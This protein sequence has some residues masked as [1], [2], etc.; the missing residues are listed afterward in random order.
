MMKTISALLALIAFAP[1]IAQKKGLALLTL[2]ALRNHPTLAAAQADVD[3]ANARGAQMSA[4]FNPMLS[5][6]GYAAAGKGESIF[7]SSVDPINYSLM[8]DKESA[9]AN[10]MFMWKVFSDGRAS[11]ARRSAIA[12]AQGKQYDLAAARLDVLR[13][14]RM[15]FSMSMHAGQNVEAEQGG[16]AAAQELLDVTQSLYDAG[17]IPEAFLFRAKADL[18]KSS[19]RLA[20]A[21]SAED[22]AMARLKEAAALPQMEMFEMGEW[23]VPLSAPPTLEEALEMGMH[24]RPE[25]ASL[26][27]TAKMYRLQARAARQSMGPEMSV[28]GMADALAA[29]NGSDSF[30]KAGLVLSLPLSDGGMRRAEAAEADAQAKAAEA[31]KEAA[32]QRIEREIAEAW[33]EWV[34]APHVMAAAEAEVQAAEEGYRVSKIRYE[35][36]KSIQAEVS[37]ALADLVAALGS[38]AQAQEF[39]HLAWTKL[40]R[41]LGK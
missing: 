12:I 21:K 7:T 9:D 19:R 6:N 38:R 16:V 11:T 13:D 27:E 10:A 36:G 23:D 1:L 22:S 25:V 31:Q 2:E 32:M 18:A 41:A 40:A 15:A 28:L 24:M 8:G 4:P 26:E 14:L 37:Q 35:A 17:K 33:A 34:A 39:Q 20:L 29:N 3:A 30:L 5:L